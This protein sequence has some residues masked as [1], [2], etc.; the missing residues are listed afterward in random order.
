MS[1]IIWP[2]YSA[3]AARAGKGDHGPDFAGEGGCLSRGHSGEVGSVGPESVIGSPPV[4]VID[5]TGM[6]RL[7]AKY[8]RE[9]FQNGGSAS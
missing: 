6:P 2:S 1:N 5:F 3:D 9:S 4:S 8:A 7:P